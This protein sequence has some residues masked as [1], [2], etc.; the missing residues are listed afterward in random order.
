[1][2]SSKAKIASCRSERS[3]P[4]PPIYTPPAPY[5]PPNPFSGETAGIPNGLSIP[6]Q[7]PLSFLMPSD[8]SCTVG[9]GNCGGMIYSLTDGASQAGNGPGRVYDISKWFRF[10]VTVTDFLDRADGRQQKRSRLQSVSLHAVR[11]SR[12]AQVTKALGVAAGI[13]VVGAVV[14]SE[15]P[16]LAAVFGSIAVAEG[17]AAGVMAVYTA[18]VCYQKE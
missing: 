7:N 16:P 5:N 10:V 18:Y 15:L 14:G 3:G 6:L 1:M 2:V 17:L 9:N 13:N 11:C 4:E 12:A 8:P